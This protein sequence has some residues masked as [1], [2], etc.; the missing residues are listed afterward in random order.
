MLSPGYLPIYRPTNQPTNTSTKLPTNLPTYQPNYLPANLPHY[1]LPTYEPNYLP[2]HQ[3]INHPT[4]LPTYLPTYRKAKFM[5]LSVASFWN[6]LKSMDDIIKETSIPPITEENWMSHFQSLHSNELL[7]L[8]QETITN[9]LRNLEQ[10]L[11]LQTHA[12]DYLMNET[13]I[14]VAVK[15]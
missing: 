12:L 13:E 9:Q 14:R 4:Y 7:N 15:R 6:R 10:E 3:P 8:N 11:S 1:E 2:T 5:S